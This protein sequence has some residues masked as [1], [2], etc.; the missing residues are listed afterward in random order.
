MRQTTFVWS[1]LHNESVAIPHDHPVFSRGA[2]GATGFSTSTIGGS[3]FEGSAY[4]LSWVMPVDSTG[5]GTGGD[6]KGKGKVP[7][8]FYLPS[9]LAER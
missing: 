4:S 5:S 3:G 8:T 7:S 2:T 6:K 1:Q 9:F